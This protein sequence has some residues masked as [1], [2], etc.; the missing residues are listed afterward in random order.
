M[1]AIIPNSRLIQ[2]V[3]GIVLCLSGVQFVRALE[4]L[5][6]LDPTRFGPGTLIV[7]LEELER[8]RPPQAVDLILPLLGHSDSQVSRTAAWILRR[9]EE[10]S[11]GVTAAAAVLSDP[12]ASVPEKVSAAISLGELRNPQATTVLRAI[13]FGQ[14]DCEVICAAVQALGDLH[15]SGVAGDLARVLS[16]HTCVQARAVAAAA[17]GNV[18]DTDM[19]E[20]VN[21]L[22]NDDV[23]VRLEV[24]WALGRKGIRTDRVIG[25]LLRVLQQDSNCKVQAAAAW[26]LAKIKDSSVLEALQ[27]AAEGRCRLASQASQ[28]ALSQM[29][30]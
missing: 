14:E 18:P 11:R 16:E 25:N 3:C 22:N 17:L 13:L 9:M 6:R 19:D 29:T 8:Y 27:I 28:W 26:A 7:A 21:A 2:V 30:H 10:S 4:P 1:K 23:Q 15:R 12:N 20:L 5:K 24:V